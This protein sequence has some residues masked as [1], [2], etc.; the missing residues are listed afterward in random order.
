MAKT[1]GLRSAFDSALE[2]FQ[3]RR[4]QPQNLPREIRVLRDPLIG[5]FRE[6]LARA[7]LSALEPDLIILDEFQRFRS[8]LGGDQSEEGKEIAELGQQFLAYPGAKILLLSA[9]PY[10]AYTLAHEGR[11]EDHHKDCRTGGR[12]SSL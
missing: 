11:A 10:K 4:G 1:N 2:H 6:C 9:A 5:R 3:R 8:L 7:C 12:E